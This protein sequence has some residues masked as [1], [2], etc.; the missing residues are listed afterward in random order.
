VTLFVYNKVEEMG[1]EEYVGRNR[2]KK[3]V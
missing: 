1:K 3:Y 2:R